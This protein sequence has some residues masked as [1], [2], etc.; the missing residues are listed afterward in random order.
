VLDFEDPVNNFFVIPIKILQ[1]KETK[2]SKVRQTKITI[3]LP[4]IDARDFHL[5]HYEA[6]VVE[7][8]CAI[9]VKMPIVPFF[10]HKFVRSINAKKKKKGVSNDQDKDA[11]Q[12]L[13]TKVLEETSGVLE[14]VY[15][16]PDGMR[17]SNK[18]Y[19]EDAIDNRLIARMEGVGSKFQTNITQSH[20]FC[21]FDAVV[22]GSD[23]RI[24]A[25]VGAVDDLTDQYGGMT[26]EEA[27]EEDSTDGDDADDDE[28]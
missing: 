16:L 21:F 7:N 26:F 10:F 11:H 9:Q 4:S 2:K 24:L 15:E 1:H 27:D 13:V 20:F 22:V 18:K 25:D 12:T 3:T 17:V 14:V 23:Q 28:M 8:G 6:Q 5:G 19:N